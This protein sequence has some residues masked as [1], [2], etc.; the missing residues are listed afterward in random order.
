MV[1]F[2]KITILKFDI[3]MCNSYKEKKTVKCS[4]KTFLYIL[5]IFKHHF[6][7]TIQKKKVSPK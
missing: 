7:W 4:T 5:N 3:Y 6:L 2:L 1:K